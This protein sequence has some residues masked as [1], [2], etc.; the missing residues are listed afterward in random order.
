MENFQRCK[1]AISIHAPLRERQKLNGDAGRIKY[2]SIHAPLRER[3]LTQAEFER[4]QNISIH[5]PLRE[6]LKF[7]FSF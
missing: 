1:Q 5:A 6:R 2:I 4:I 3:Q 7:F